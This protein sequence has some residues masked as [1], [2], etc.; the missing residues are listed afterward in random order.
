VVGAVFCLYAWTDPNEVP[1]ATRQKYFPAGLAILGFP[2]GSVVCA[3]GLAS[4]GKVVDSS[5]HTDFIAGLA[6]LAGLGLGGFGGALTAFLLGLRHYNRVRANQEAS[7]P[8]N[9]AWPLFLFLNRY[10]EKW[11]GPR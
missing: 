10:Y 5:Y 8:F 3:W 9:A 1:K 4:A 7:H 11:L 2:V 6:G